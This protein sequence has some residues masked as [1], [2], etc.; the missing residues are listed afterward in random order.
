MKKEFRRYPKYFDNYIRAFDKMV[1]AINESGRTTTTWQSGE[2]V[3]QWWISDISE[4]QGQVLFDGFEPL[5]V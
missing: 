1:K 3:M 5:D 2:E 4:I